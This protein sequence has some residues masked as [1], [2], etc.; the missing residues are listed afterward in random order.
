MHLVRDRR[1]WIEVVTA[2]FHGHADDM[3]HHDEWLVGV[4]HAGVQDFFCRGQRRQSTAGRVILIEPGERHD[5]QAT[6]DQGF[7]YSMLS[8]PQAWLRDERGGQDAD[9]GFRQ[10][11]AYDR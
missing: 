4:T 10:T 3:H 8:L 1:R 11:L 6:Q 7:R 5:G 9:I 2:H